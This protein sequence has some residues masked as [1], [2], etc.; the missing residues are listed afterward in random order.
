MTDLALERTLILSDYCATPQRLTEIVSD[1]DD[2]ELK[3]S[4]RPDAWSIRQ[5]V[6]HI[7][8]G[9]DLWSL[10]IKAALGN[11]RLIYFGRTGSTS[12]SCWRLCRKRGIGPSRSAGPVMKINL[13]QWPR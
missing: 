5:I 11:P 3:R 10:A 2:T 13:P 8:D 12:C 9:D 4:L 1:L 6:H 7:V